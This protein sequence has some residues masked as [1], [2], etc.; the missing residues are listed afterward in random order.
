MKRRRR[1]VFREEVL[2]PWLTLAVVLG[3]W[4]V[5]AFLLGR[6]PG[7]PHSVLEVETAQAREREPA[8]SPN[9][10]APNLV[11]A[12][13]LPVEV[14]EGDLAVLLNKELQVPVAGVAATTLRS[15]FQD[16]RGGGRQHEA[17]DILAPRGTP[18]VAT[19]DGRIMKLFNSVRGGLTIYQYDLAEQY[20]YYY[21]H[22]DSYARDLAEGQTVT[23]GQT[24]GFVGTTGNAP[25]NTPHLHF[26]I[27][28]LDAAKRWWEGVP[29]DPILVLR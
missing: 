25:A 22:L 11:D 28:K 2:A 6:H 15:T 27:F 26:A 19:I 10:P 5:G 21:A 7:A 4:W 1:R 3:L 18:V 23:R 20:C 12:V 17:L 14:D 29:L 24:I 13:T 16:A 9:R 8:P